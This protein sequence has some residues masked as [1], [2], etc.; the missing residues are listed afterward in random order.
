VENGLS[1]EGFLGKKLISD[2]YTVQMEGE[3]R[4]ADTDNHNSGLPGR[5]RVGL[6]PS[7]GVDRKLI[8]CM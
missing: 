1:F 5:R 7:S 8:D 2:T 6:F 4:Q 3:L